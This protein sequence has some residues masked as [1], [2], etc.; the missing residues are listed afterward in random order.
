MQHGTDTNHWWIQ[1]LTNGG[2]EGRSHTC[3][4]IL[5]NVLEMVYPGALRSKRMVRLLIGDLNE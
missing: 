1:D 3:K 2:G 4:R 5:G